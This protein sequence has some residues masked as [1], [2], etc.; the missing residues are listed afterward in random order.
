MNSHAR[1]LPV[2]AIGAFAGIRCAEIM[3]LDWEDIKWDRGHI[4]IAGRKAKTAAR[5][6]VP[7][8]ENLKAWLAP[9]RESTGK[10]VA[11]TAVAGAMS[12]L[13]VKAKI[14]G[15]WRQ[16]ALRHS[17]I[18]YRVALTG[19]VART[20]LEAGNSPK[21]IFRHYRE[22]VTEEDAKAWFSIMPPDR[23][24]PKELPWSIRERLRR[25]C[26]Q[27]ENQ[28]VVVTAKIA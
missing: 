27:L 12:D 14:P 8:P 1:I 9:W 11:L 18:S 3:R 6:L 7:L 13:A 19:D 4:E 25:L 15:G 16:N 2:I 24:L 23:W 26:M 10:I 17:F 22:V 21:V 20:A 5:R 28:R